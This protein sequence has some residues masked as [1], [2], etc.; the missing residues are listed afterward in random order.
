MTWV[1]QI[2][3]LI[4]EWESVT[5]CPWQPHMTS[6]LLPPLLSCGLFNGQVDENPELDKIGNA[7]D[8]VPTANSWTALDPIP[9]KFLSRN[10]NW[11]E[12]FSTHKESSEEH[13]T[14]K[15]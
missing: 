6:Q 5:L 1:E 14:H 9:G 7:W 8:T 2:E 10:C 11:L 15:T 4:A 3:L 13:R 12:S